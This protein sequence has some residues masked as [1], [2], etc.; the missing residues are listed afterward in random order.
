MFEFFDGVFASSFEQWPSRPP[1][2]P[3]REMRVQTADGV[4]LRLRRIPPHGGDSGEPPVMLL[5]GLAAN[6]RGFHLRER[7]FARW[8]AERGHDVWLPELRGHGASEVD[9]WD[10]CLDDY[11]E[12]DL[13]AIVEAIVAASRR[14]ELRWVGH[15]MGGV[16]LM[17]YG[18][19][20]PEAP[21]ERGVAI[22]SALDYKAGSTEFERLLRIRPL[23][24]R[25]RSVPYGL[26]MRL[27]APAIGRTPGALDRFNV[28][29]SNIEDE[30][31]R[32]VHARCFHSIPV[33]LLESLATTFDRRGLRL[34]SGFSFLDDVDRFEI[35][36]LLVAGSR[37][38]QVSVEAVE[39][40]ARMLGSRARTSLHGAQRG[41]VD[42]YG[43]WDLLV[44]RR[45]SDEV[46]PEIHDWL[47]MELR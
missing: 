40:T 34:T 33:R 17:C 45:A 16:L 4:S 32:A 2:A 47:R 30:I 11:L 13:P 42:H 43:H 25:V 10:W 5:H 15:S 19:L 14:D 28:W 20:K 38:L 39:Q 41:D 36:I 37:D 9:G 22:G 23:L 7:S 24:Q 31:S 46:W 21:I 3:A 18:I 8:L 26:L 29:P 6:H 12:R 35:P 44:G 1:P 27:V